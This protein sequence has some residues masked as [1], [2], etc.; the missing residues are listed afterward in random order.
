MVPSVSRSG[1]QAAEPGN[2]VTAV[3]LP[4]KAGLAGC[5]VGCGRPTGRFGRCATNALQAAGL[6]L[7]NSCFAD[8]IGGGITDAGTTSGAAGFWDCARLSGMAPIIATTAMPT[9]ISVPKYLERVFMAYRIP[10]II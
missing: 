7:K 1:L 5:F 8:D 4:P 3:Q 9:P 6:F 2:A 10:I